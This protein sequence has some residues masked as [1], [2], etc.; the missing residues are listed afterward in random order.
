MRRPDVP[1]GSGEGVV[2]GSHLGVLLLPALSAGVSG[3]ELTG[4]GA[5][6]EVPGGPLVSQG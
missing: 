3:R 5:L 4:A 6:D 2:S 1:Q